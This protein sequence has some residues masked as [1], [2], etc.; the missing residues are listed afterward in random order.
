[1]LVI[2]C[3]CGEVWILHNPSE[4]EEDLQAVGF[5]SSVDQVAGVWSPEAKTGSHIPAEKT[6]DDPCK[7]I[8]DVWTSCALEAAEAAQALR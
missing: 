4:V 8:D 1:M 7:A 5:V 6:K 2:A 3:H